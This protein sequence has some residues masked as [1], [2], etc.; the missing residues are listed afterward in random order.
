[1]KTTTNPLNA[2]I[3]FVKSKLLSLVVWTKGSRNGVREG[4]NRIRSSS[5][6]G[7][8]IKLSARFTSVIFYPNFLPC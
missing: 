6:Y 7:F 2:N 3:H 5:A 1:M 4:V 8:P